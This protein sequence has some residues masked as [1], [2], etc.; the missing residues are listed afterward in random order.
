MIY[1]KV[2]KHN[3]KLWFN[4]SLT[5]NVCGHGLMINLKDVCKIIFE[6]KY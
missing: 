6:V 4:E 5:T 1:V 2:Q 3:L